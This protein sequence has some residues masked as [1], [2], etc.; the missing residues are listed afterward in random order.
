[1]R[2]TDGRKLDHKTLEAIRIRAVMAVEAGQS[3]E[4]VIASLSMSRPII[5]RWMAAYA[6]GGMEALKA[7]KLFGRPPKISIRQMR[8]LYKVITEKNPLQLKF[9]FALWTRELVRMLIKDKFGV[10]MSAVSVG[11]LLAKIGLSCQKPLARA[12][13]QDEGLVSTWIKKEYPKLAQKAKIEGAEI[14]FA[15]EA[16]VKSD[17]H[18]GTTWGIKGQTPIITRTGARFGL[19]MISAITAKGRMRFMVVKGT[20]KAD[21]FCE[22]LKRL[23]YN[24]KKKVYLI[25]DGHPTH[26]SKMVKEM[27]KKF[28]GKLQLIFLPPYS[29]ELN[30]DELVWN[31]L[32]GK[33]GRKSITGPE[34]MQRMIL[35]ILRSMQSSTSLI[36]RLF[37]EPS[38]AYAAW[39]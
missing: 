26:K 33:M 16:G 39:K 31:V 20:V 19:N 30:P 22:F 32:K 10:H 24:A 6:S 25:V 36:K 15:D 27:V 21:K 7:K 3:P 2:S 1:M 4:K 14:Y 34:H 17:H 11:R 18:S 38:V 8:W 37:Q 13:Q 35:S 5:Y 28:K 23:M 12:F 9:E 29:P